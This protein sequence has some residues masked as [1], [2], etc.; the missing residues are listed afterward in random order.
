ML[1]RTLGVPQASPKLPTARLFHGVSDCRGNVSP[2]RQRGSLVD[3]AP[4]RQLLA[5]TAAPAGPGRQGRDAVLSQAN[6]WRAIPRLREPMPAAPA[7][8]GRGR[9][10]LATALRLPIPFLPL[11]QN[12]TASQTLLPQLAW[13]PR[14]KG[15]F[16]C[17]CL[18]VF[19]KF[20]FI[21]VKQFKKWKN[22]K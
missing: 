1:L 12:P 3:R 5:V 11:T 20:N 16:I 17:I 14:G 8:R 19:T 22:S 15:F 7:P 6:T 4:A 10:H 2:R 9:V 21:S 13:P 18:C